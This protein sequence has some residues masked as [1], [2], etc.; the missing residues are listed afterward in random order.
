MDGQTDGRTDG[1]ADRRTDGR[2]DGWTTGLRELDIQPLGES[3]IS[4][5]IVHQFK[6]NLLMESPDNYILLTISV[7]NQ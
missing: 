6:I 1:R 3:A 7:N 2:T 4:Q 5:P